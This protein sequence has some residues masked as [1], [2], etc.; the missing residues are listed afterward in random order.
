MYTLKDTDGTHYTTPVYVGTEAE[1]RTATK[2]S[3]KT[4][5]VVYDWGQLNGTLYAR[6]ERCSDC[7]ATRARYTT[8]PP[9]E[10]PKPNPTRS[11]RF[12]ECTN[13]GDLALVCS[14]CL[15]C[16]HCCCCGG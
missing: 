1:I 11:L 7:I 13:C 14:M 6:M 10:P 4:W 16:Y 12:T 8:D 5:I 2:C 15:S 9:I 3:H